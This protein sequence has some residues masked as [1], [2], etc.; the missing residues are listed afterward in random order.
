MERMK[1]I[2]WNGLLKSNQRS[3]EHTLKVLS[4]LVVMFTRVV[5][6]ELGTPS[7]DPPTLLV[8]LILTTRFSGM[9]TAQRC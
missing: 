5:T 4:S 1:N 3:C 9:I 8:L 7:G 2:G 6:P